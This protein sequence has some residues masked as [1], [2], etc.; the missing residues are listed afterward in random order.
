MSNNNNNNK[1]KIC[2]IIYDRPIVDLKYR[3]NKW[4]DYSD[5]RLEVHWKIYRCKYEGNV[6]TSKEE[7]ERMEADIQ[8]FISEKKTRNAKSPKER[9]ELLVA[10]KTRGLIHPFVP[11]FSV[12]YD[13]IKVL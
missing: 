7:Y 2:E 3:K 11:E 8:P 4:K 1:R 13:M 6:Y 5:R 9:A 12:W 10:N